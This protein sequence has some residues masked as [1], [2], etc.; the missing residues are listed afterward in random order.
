MA[1][2]DGNSLTRCSPTVILG[3]SST[4][5]FLDDKITRII[6]RINL[7]I[8]LFYSASEVRLKGTK[9]LCQSNCFTPITLDATTPRK[10]STWKWK[11]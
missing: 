2:P 7:F 6:I 4:V 1:A 8:L 3:W 10:C 9:R 5:L 11:N